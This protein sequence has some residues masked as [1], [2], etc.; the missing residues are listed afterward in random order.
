MPCLK[1]SEFLCRGMS[2][3]SSLAID[4]TYTR[5]AR[6]SYMDQVRLTLSQPYVDSESLKFPMEKD[7]NKRSLIYQLPFMVKLNG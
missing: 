3:A 7:T 1:I 4:S 2:T 5:S 6:Y